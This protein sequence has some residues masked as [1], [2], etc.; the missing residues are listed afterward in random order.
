MHIR[1]S[2]TEGDPLQQ[3]DAWL[4]CPAHFWPTSWFRHSPEVVSKS[5]GFPSLLQHEVEYCARCPESKEVSFPQRHDVQEC[6]SMI[7][8]KIIIIIIIIIVSTTFGHIIPA[9][10]QRILFP[11]VRR[12]HVGVILYRTLGPTNL[13]NTIGAK[14]SALWD[15]LH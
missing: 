14:P 11:K 12:Y 10:W 6:P 5:P 15:L 3:Q 4:S 7:C 13:M 2:H 1:I 9:Q 8:T